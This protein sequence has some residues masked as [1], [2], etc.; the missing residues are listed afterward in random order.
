MFV[1]GHGCLALGSA[2]GSSKL[3]MSGVVNMFANTQQFECRVRA[4]TLKTTKVAAMRLL[5]QDCKDVPVFSSFQ[6]S[7]R[8]IALVSGSL[9]LS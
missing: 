2:M 3:I 5:L 6:L 1:Q 4:D 9:S 8:P 7:S